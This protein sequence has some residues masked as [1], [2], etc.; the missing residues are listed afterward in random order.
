[1]VSIEIHFL[2]AIA[3]ILSALA[4][5]QARELTHA[6]IYFTLMS[7]VLAV[8]FYALGAIYVAVF[9]LL[10]YAGAVTVLFLA[11]LHTVGRHE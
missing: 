8:V 10:V 9:Q 5:T 4:A 3:M 1:M 11:A 2:L 7:V 6:I